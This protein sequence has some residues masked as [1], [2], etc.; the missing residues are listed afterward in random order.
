MPGRHLNLKAM[1]RTGQKLG[2]FRGRNPSLTATITIS[3]PPPVASTTISPPPQSHHHHHLATTTT[4][5]LRPPPPPHDHHLHLNPHSGNQKFS[6]GESAAFLI[7]IL[8]RTL[9]WR[10]RVHFLENRLPFFYF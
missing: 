9:I 2:G 6:P 7:K 8:I 1:D 10:L 3:R 5:T 4:T